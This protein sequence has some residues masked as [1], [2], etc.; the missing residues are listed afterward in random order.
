[1]V[2]VR[3]KFNGERMSWSESD[4]WDPTSST[5]VYALGQPELGHVLSMPRIESHRRNLRYENSDKA[6]FDVGI[7][8]YSVHK[9]QIGEQ[10]KHTNEAAQVP[11][12][13]QTNS[14]SMLYNSDQ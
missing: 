5:S 9:T 2:P 3:I 7:P 1:V 6:D 14:L 10:W 11:P 8:F 4:E 13:L 12:Y